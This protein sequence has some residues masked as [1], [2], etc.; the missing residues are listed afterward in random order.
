MSKF[1]AL[2]GRFPIVSNIKFTFDPECPAFNRIESKNVFISG[3]S[4]LLDRDYTIS[5]REFLFQGY[6]GYENFPSF[7]NLDTT[8]LETVPDILLKYFDIVRDLQPEY[9]NNDDLSFNFGFETINKNF[10]KF[11]KSTVLFKDQRPIINLEG[12]SEER[13]I[14]LRYK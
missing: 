11:L 13:I 14:P 1:P 12:L 7:I 6:D 5:T 2:E 10:F 4:I 3:Q 8:D 9:L